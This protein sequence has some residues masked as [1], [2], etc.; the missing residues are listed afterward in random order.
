MK[1]FK[2]KTQGLSFRKFDLHVHTP[3]SACFSGPGV[4][5]K[6]VVQKSIQ[7]GLSAIAVTDH[8]TGGWIDKVK[9]A[10]EG[11]DLTVFPG[12]EITVGDAHNHIIAIL[13]V[14]KTT[15]DVEDLLTTV[16]ILHDKFGKKDAFSQ[17]SVVE[18]IEI[19]TG[20]KFNAIAILAHIDSTNGVFEQ[21]R[22]NPRREVI[23]HPRLLAVE[24]VNYQKVSKFLDGNDPVYER[25]LAVYQASDNPCL[26]ENGNLIVCGPCAGNHNIDG[27]GFKYSYFKVD[28]NISLESLRQCFI[29]P[30]VRIRQSF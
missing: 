7:M 16:G 1:E 12:T 5:P 8:N 19:V 15:R 4:T 21:M 23:Q 2:I 11:T 30:E 20:D 13:D 3:A 25:R 6:Q 26:D 22:G 10:A 17:K 24:A 9:K 29:D 14:D 18:V 27:I 28:E